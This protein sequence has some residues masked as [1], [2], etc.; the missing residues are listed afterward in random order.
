[1]N[2]MKSSPNPSNNQVGQLINSLNN[3]ETYS[4]SKEL[5]AFL[6]QQRYET[7]IVIV[8]ATILGVIIPIVVSLIN[9]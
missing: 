3:S 7:K 1:M 6:Q 8:A 4:K 2:N 5:E 9:R